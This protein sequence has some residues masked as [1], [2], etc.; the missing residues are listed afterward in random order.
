MRRIR[1]S[2]FLLTCLAS[3]VAMLIAAPLGDSYQN[4]DVENC[5][6]ADSPCHGVQDSSVIIV[7]DGPDT[8]HTNTPAVYVITVLGGPSETYGYFVL[9]EDPDGV[10]RDLQGEFLFEV[11]PNSV[12]RIGETNSFV[13]EFTPPRN[14]IHLKMTVAAVSSDNSG[15]PTGDGWNSVEKDIKVEYPSSVEF[16]GLD[17]SSNAHLL[18]SG[19]LA[20]GFVMW[21]AFTLI[22]RKVKKEVSRA[23]RRKERDN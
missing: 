20:V 14:A 8:V 1:R 23:A 12:T 18:G 15:G 6:D 2:L 17:V 22:D 7:I 21:V 16:P 5:G 9:V 10:S 19:I 4:V 13:I 3:V 11:A